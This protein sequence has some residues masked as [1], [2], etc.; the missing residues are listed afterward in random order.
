MPIPT[1]FSDHQLQRILDEASI[2]LCACPA[3]VCRQIQG[4]RAL[5]S[6]QESCLIDPK[7]DKQTHALIAEATL[8]AHAR[9]ERCLDDI[10]TQEG[11]DRDS[12]KMPPG[13]RR[14]R[15]EAIR[16]L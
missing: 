3:Q 16:N 6:Y 5:H 8:E 4:L 15:D 9:L 7:T 1:R 12:L 14:L 2:Y 10:L 11:W 13:L